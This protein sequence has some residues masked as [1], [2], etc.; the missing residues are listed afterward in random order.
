ML[1]KTNSVL[2]IKQPPIRLTELIEQR[3]RNC[4]ELPGCAA[5]A[6]ANWPDGQITSDIQNSC[7][8]PE[9]KI[10]RFPRRANQRHELA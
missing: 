9:S 3:R 5:K 10:F 4:V 1:A 8:A 7:Q 6:S 2:R